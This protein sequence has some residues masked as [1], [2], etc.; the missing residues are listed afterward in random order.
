MPRVQRYV[1]T[2]GLNAP[3]T[4]FNYS[5]FSLAASGERHEN[6]N[7]T[8]IGMRSGVWSLGNRTGACV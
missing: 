4:T 6:K 2:A 7:K 3:I 8:A 1:L 5:T